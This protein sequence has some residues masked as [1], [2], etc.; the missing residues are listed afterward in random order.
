MNFAI[1]QFYFGR[2]LAKLIDKYLNF[3]QERSLLSMNPE[4]YFSKSSII[5][6]LA[7]FQKLFIWSDHFFDLELIFIFLIFLSFI[8]SSQIILQISFEVLYYII[9]ARPRM[10]YYFHFPVSP[11]I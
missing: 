10:N 9:M 5:P 11:Q 3:F 1:W 8:L 4:T 6:W 7:Y 2:V